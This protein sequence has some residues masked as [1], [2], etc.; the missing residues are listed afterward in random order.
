MFLEFIKKSNYSHILIYYNTKLHAEET[1]QCE[2]YENI[3]IK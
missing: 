3:H 2:S 1:S